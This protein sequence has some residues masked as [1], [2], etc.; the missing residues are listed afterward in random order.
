M[1]PDVIDM[2]DSPLVVVGRAVLV[3]VGVVLAGT[4]PRNILFAMNL[5]Y[6]T[7]VPWAIPVTAVYLWFFWRYL[8]GSTERRQLLRANRLS[9][10]VWLWALAAGVLGVA[11]LVLLLNVANHFVALPE[12]KLPDLTG[13]PKLTVLALLL[14]AAPIAA[15]IEESAFRGYMQ[16]PIERRC[17]LVVAILITGTMFALVHLD[18]QLILWPYYVAVAALYGVVTSWTNSILPAMVLHTI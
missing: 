3:G 10:R 11:S 13:V 8:Q 9:C 15:L 18:F 14:A 1:E 7:G 17:G 6:F 12:Q 16:G 4:M 2:Q 5:R